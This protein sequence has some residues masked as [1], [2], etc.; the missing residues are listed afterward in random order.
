MA[1]VHLVL[2]IGLVTVCFFY[3]Y[4]FPKKPVN[5]LV[6]VIALSILPVLSQFRKGDYNGGLYQNAS[7]AAGFF[8]SLSEGNLIPRWAERL[9]TYFGYPAYI[10]MYH[11]PFYISSVF[12]LLGFS[13]VN[14]VKLTFVFSYILSGVSMWFFVKDKLS[15]WGT[16]L[17]V[18]LYQFAPYRFIDMYFRLDVGEAVAFAFMPLQFYCIDKYADTKKP[19]YL[20]WGSVFT[21][22][23]ILSHPALSVM[24]V[25]LSLLYVVWMRKW[26]GI[27]PVVSGALLSAYYWFPI[28]WEAPVSQIKAYTQGEMIAGVTYIKFGELIF[29]PWRWGLL[30]Q[31]NNAELAFVMGYGAVVVLLMGMGKIFN[32]PSRQLVFWFLACWASIFM[33]LQISKPLWQVIPL[34]NNFQFSWR[35]LA[36]LALATSVLG[37]I[38]VNKKPGYIA[39]IIASITVLGSVLNWGHRESSPI[40]ISDA[41]LR[42]IMPTQ[43]R[44]S[45]TGFPQALPIWIDLK[46]QWGD[47]NISGP[48][49]ILSGKADVRQIFRNS[50]KHV[51]E[52]D[53][54]EASVFKENTYYYPGWRL[55][56]NGKQKNIEYQD[57]NFPGVMKFSLEPGRYTTELKFGNSPDRNLSLFVSA[58]T[59]IFLLGITGTPLLWSSFRSESH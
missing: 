36:L 31:G 55:M 43:A 34:I 41:K 35:F 49:E 5:L 51:Y 8:D 22:I 54:K 6:L 15:G 57:K 53:L 9:D 7:F 38:V 2:V 40:V 20:F 4:V 46:N 48:I 18:V 32:K 21:A 16:F 13:F 42:E 19:K 23:L 44:I 24:T 29:S 47:R 50:T 12:H 3:Y 25:G 33:M 30:F 10:F 58:I 1:V 39:I 28:I 56:V 59:G 17:S 52:L 11:T 27:L 26:T 37:G 45:Q 14:S